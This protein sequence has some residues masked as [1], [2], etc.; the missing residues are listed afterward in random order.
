MRRDDDVSLLAWSATDDDTKFA[1]NGLARSPAHFRKYPDLVLDKRT[2]IV[3][4]ESMSTM[5]PRGLQIKLDIRRDLNERMVA[6]AVLANRKTGPYKRSE[7]SLILPILFP[8]PAFSRSHDG[9]ECIRFSDPL[10]VRSTF[11]RKAKPEPLCFIRQVQGANLNREGDGLSLSS[12]V[13]RDYVTSFTYPI[14]TQSGRRHFPAIMGGFSDRSGRYTFVL[15]L[16]SRTLDRQKFIILVDYQVRDRQIIR[17][18]GIKVTVLKPQKDTALELNIA[19]SLATFRGYRRDFTPCHLPD[20]DDNTIPMDSI[21]YIGYFSDYW[22]RDGDDNV[23]IVPGRPPRY[24]E[25]RSLCAT[26][27]RVGW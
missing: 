13:W 8:E 22:I 24:S 4:S 27:A 6:Y 14:Q 3:N 25:P 1:P 17:E 20:R 21:V 10:W 16:T 15:E 19:A 7:V 12:T 11:V 26:Q 18:S 9:K 2:I 5:T 23:D